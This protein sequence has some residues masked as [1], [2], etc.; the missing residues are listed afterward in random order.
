VALAFA[1]CSS[2]ALACPTCSPN[3]GGPDQAA[4]IWMT[5]MMCLAPLVAIGGVVLW[6]RSEVRKAAE[7]E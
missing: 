7:Q 6:V 3:Q 2:T 4:F 1:L 5:V